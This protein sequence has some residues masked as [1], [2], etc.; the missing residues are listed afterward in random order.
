MVMQIL[1]PNA[2]DYADHSMWP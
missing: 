2:N 1:A